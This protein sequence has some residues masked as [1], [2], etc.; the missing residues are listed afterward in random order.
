M[1]GVG[2][3]VR[4]WVVRRKPRQGTGPDSPGKACPLPRR[5]EACLAVSQLQFAQS[6]STWLTDS[7]LEPS[8]G[9]LTR[10]QRKRPLLTQHC[11][12]SP[13]LSC[14]KASCSGPSPGQMAP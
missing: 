14:R 3:V 6:Q 7:S 8:P 9:L 2:E 5:A 4:G 11:W 1:L 10:E 13:F 12:A